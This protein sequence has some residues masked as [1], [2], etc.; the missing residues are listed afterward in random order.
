MAANLAKLPGLLPRRN[1]VKLLIRRQR[2]NIR[3]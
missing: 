2:V 1:L 3:F